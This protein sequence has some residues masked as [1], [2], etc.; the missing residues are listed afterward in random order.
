MTLLLLLAACTS[1]EKDTGATDDTATAPCTGP[2]A[3]DLTL[4]M[5]TDLQASMDEPAVG[6]FRGSVY[7]EADA[8][9][10][11]P[12]DGS[13]SLLDFTIEDVDLSSG[14]DGD[15]STSDPI[16]PQIVWVLGCLDSDDNE[17]DSN[18]AVTIPNENK[19]EVLCGAPT[20]FEIYLGILQP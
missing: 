4:A 16:D 12:N 9:A 19:V 15:V 10:I 6:T 13:S 17:C 11:G 7:A 20:P 3:L 5:T 8:S 14:V 18:D 2:G 1:S